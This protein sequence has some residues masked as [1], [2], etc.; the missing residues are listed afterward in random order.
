ML[1][2]QTER[3]SLEILIK[4]T[5]NIYRFISNINNNK[6]EK[7][8]NVRYFKR[9]KISFWYFFGSSRDD[10]KQLV[11]RFVRIRLNRKLKLR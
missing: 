11:T 1:K 9:I 8:V 2:H 5:V 4:K 7:R 10:L 3:L 6:L